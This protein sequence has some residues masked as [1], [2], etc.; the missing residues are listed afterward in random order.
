[1]S[2]EKQSAAT[3]GNSLTSLLTSLQQGVVAINSLTQTLKTTFPS[4]S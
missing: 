3:S 4:T 1:M 2:D